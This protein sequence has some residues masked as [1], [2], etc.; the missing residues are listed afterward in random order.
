M[1]FVTH[2]IGLCNEIYCQLGSSHN[3]CVYQKALI[4]ELYNLGAQSVEFEKH[5][6]VFFKDSNGTVHTIGDERIDILVRFPMHSDE[7]AI[8]VIELKAVAKN[9]LN[10][11]TEQ[12]RKYK[13]SLKQLNIHPNMFL[14]INFPQQTETSLVEY[15]TYSSDFEKICKNFTLSIDS[16]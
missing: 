8:I 1:D 9:R 5:V 7:V 12:L 4:V 15:M 6:P 13:T 16:K 11:Y 14:L 10:T 2:I 3:E